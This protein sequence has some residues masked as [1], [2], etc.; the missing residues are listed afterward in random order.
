[1]S[2]PMPPEWL[3]ADGRGGYALGS[4]D[5]SLRRRY[6][7]LLTVV[8]SGRGRR[9]LVVDLSEAWAEPSSKAFRWE[10]LEDV[11]FVGSPLPCHRFRLG[12]HQLERTLARHPATGALLLRYR[13]GS[14]SGP[15]QLELRPWIAARFYHDLA[16][17]NERIQ[18]E[19]EE[20]SPK[21]WRFRPYPF[22][23]E[24]W[25]L[26]SQGTWT[27]DPG[28]IEDW[29]YSEERARGYSFQEDLF[30]PGGIQGSLEPGESWFLALA[31][32][33]PEEEGPPLAAAD[34]AA[35]FRRILPESPSAR[36]PAASPEGLD[37]SG[38]RQ[39]IAPLE[40]ARD[41]YR[42]KPGG[43]PGGVLAGYPWFESWGRDT[44]LSLEGL[45][46]PGEEEAVE[47]ILRAY[48]EGRKDGLLPNRL[49]DGGNRP[50]DHSADAPLWFIHAWHRWRRK[51]RQVDLTD[52]FEAARDIFD[53]YVR[54]T[55]FG[56]R[57]D[58]ED[59]LLWAG[60]PG[61]ALTWMDAKV[62]DQVITPRDGKPVELQALWYS[63]CRILEKV[64]SP[65]DAELSQ[66]AKLAAD[67]VGESFPKVFWS[68]ELGYLAD[69]IQPDGRPDLS[70]RPNQLFALSLPYRLLD[71]AR[72]AHL[73]E[74]VEAQLLTPYGLR[75]LSPE[76]PEYQGSYQGDVVARDHAYH[77]G[78]VWPWLMGPYG[79][80]CLAVRGQGEARKIRERLE[81]LL[82]F[83][84]KRGFGHLPEIFDG[85]QP[86]TP[87]GCPA[88][89][90][91]VAQVLALWKK[92]DRVESYDPLGPGA[93]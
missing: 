50:N 89:A 32:A 88:Q 20:L 51:A 9:N 11:H 34:L 43:L 8:Q 66:A 6:H 40:A 56:I 79:R 46:A 30:V 65:R 31:S 4:S 80:A 81:P 55:R 13:L 53:H 54:G 87:R 60:E 71:R 3:L 64:S 7:S 42:L 73:L 33:E 35:S 15:I 16:L 36:A 93:S 63:A 52:L 27:S 29:S 61:L 45:F 14:D 72:G 75:T 39:K 37:L 74:V 69:R 28:W 58:P 62:D 91:S 86:H 12:P 48:A 23:P 26:A 59:G 19:V 38:P 77:Q 41:A 68:P 1:M 83:A 90:W 49:G 44:F 78:T 70:L 92:L 21:A 5:R 17:K 76:H 18:A 25:I 85:D 24:F 57:V 2:S 10:P 22:E 82:D 67:R 47:G 84:A